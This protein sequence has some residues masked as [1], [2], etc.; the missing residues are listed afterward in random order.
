[1][2]MSCLP[3]KE[4]IDNGM[5]IEAARLYAAVITHLFS[6]DDK[7]ITPTLR[8]IDREAPIFYADVTENVTRPAARR[9]LGLKLTDDQKTRLMARIQEQC[10]N[11]EKFIKWSRSDTAT[12][13]QNAAVWTVS[14]FE[15]LKADQDFYI[16]LS[17]EV[18][19]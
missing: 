1:M 5:G 9:L 15:W 17:A 18:G 3:C 6:D 11:A 10:Y 19:E 14:I 13:I 4:E 8:V 2:I 12:I 7:R 16:A